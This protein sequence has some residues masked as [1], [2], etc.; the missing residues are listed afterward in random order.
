M[1]IIPQSVN[2]TSS[3]IE[4]NIGISKEFNNFELV[5]ALA[6]KDVMKANKIIN[7]FAKNP[8]N[9]SPIAT[10]TILYNFFSKLLIAHGSSDK[11]PKGLGIK[12]KINPYFTKDYI[13]ALK[14]YPLQKNARIIGY[15]REF[16]MK[17]KGKDNVS[18]NEL[19]LMRDLIFKILH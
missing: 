19:D 18:T 13:A 10:T 6:L 5:N 8:K 3:D 12:L 14:N 7:Y 17:L 4:K 16:D 11:T 2:I 9:N 1:L 15:L